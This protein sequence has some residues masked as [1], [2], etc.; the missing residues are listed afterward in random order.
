MKIL[1]TKEMNKI[2]K[3]ALAMVIAGTFTFS[4]TAAFA[5]ELK[6]ADQAA[7]VELKTEVN[8]QNTSGADVNTEETL[9]EAE[10]K[11]E[12]IKKE[13]PTS[14][15]GDF[16]YFTKTS[17]E[18]I[19]LAL[20][21]DKVKE[22]E[23]LASYASERLAEAEAL[24]DAGKEEEALN[25]IKKAT[26]FMENAGKIVEEGSE[27]ETETKDQDSKE[28]ET[29]K[30]TDD[31]T[32]IEDKETEDTKLEEVENKLSQNIIALKA[33]L[34]KVKNPT[35][36][37]ALKKNI[38]KSYA[39]LAKKLEKIESTLAKEGKENEQTEETAIGGTAA[40]SLV[41]TEGSTVPATK[42]DG[43]QTP[44]ADV[45]ETEANVSVPPVIVLPEKPKV[46]QPEQDQKEEAEAKQQQAAKS[47]V[48]QARTA[49]KAEV[50]QARA[51]AKAEVKQQQS[52]AKAEVKQQR[53]AVKQTR[54]AAKQTVKEKH[55]EAK[56]EL[57]EL[58]DASKQQ[59]K[60]EIKATV[61]VGKEKEGKDKE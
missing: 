14:L 21:F 30:S 27:K 36:K 33:A 44:T 37:A 28:S 58:H 54:E 2:A 46:I 5:D 9:K 17:L 50:K 3:S 49:A 24:F 23:L 11:L 47:E 18:K 55:Q 39:K 8:T 53:E 51:T 13:N 59:V 56:K 16:F 22:A 60:T 7:S 52:A 40:I 43:S 15:P 1:S 38:E 31:K 32:E 35:A 6:S 19:K 48:K 57:K 42:T 20:T 45:T 41:A 12:E 29:E 25:A 26:A 61:K 34:E 10:T 4:A